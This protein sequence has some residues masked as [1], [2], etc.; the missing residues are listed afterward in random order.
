MEPDSTFMPFTIMQ[1]IEKPQQAHSRQSSGIS[2]HRPA[3]QRSLGFSTSMSSRPQQTWAPTGFIEVQHPQA[4]SAPPAFD[5]HLLG[6]DIEQTVTASQVTDYHSVQ[7][8]PPHLFGT[9]LSPVHATADPSFSRSWPSD[10]GQVHP[11]ESPQ[12]PS[13]QQSYHP[14]SL[15][16]NDY[17]SP[18]GMVQPSNAATVQGGQPAEHAIRG[19][20][21]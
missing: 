17:Q 13:G 15:H 2:I 11:P 10:Q 1:T 8:Q 18:A 4:A 21:K 9:Q 14:W 7:S 16:K 20:S 5:P 6:F 19:F 3:S 12:D